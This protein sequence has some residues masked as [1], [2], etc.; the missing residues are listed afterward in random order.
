MSLKNRKYQTR[1]DKK[2]QK[3]LRADASCIKCIWRQKIVE[4]EMT[5]KCITDLEEAFF[6]VFA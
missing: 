3:T 5:Q 1:K 4:A 2:D 6:V